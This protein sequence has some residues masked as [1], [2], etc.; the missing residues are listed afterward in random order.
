LPNCC[1]LHSATPGRADRHRDGLIWP[2]FL[3]G[4]DNPRKRRDPEALG[5][6]EIG[7]IETEGLSMMAFDMGIACIGVPGIQVVHE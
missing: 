5:R 3:Y 2:A 4:N 6:S 1:A 7:E